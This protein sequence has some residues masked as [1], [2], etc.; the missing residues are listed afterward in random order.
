MIMHNYNTDNKNTQII[1]TIVFVEIEIIIEI[2]C[3]DFD[4][5]NK[6]VGRVNYKHRFELIA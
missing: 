1:A 4:W 2:S 3:F 6:N 5:L